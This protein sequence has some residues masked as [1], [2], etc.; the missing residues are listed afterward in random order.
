MLVVLVPAEGRSP[1]LGPEA[2]R[3]LSEVGVT[4]VSLAGD[5]E[6]VGVVLQGWAFD[7]GRSGAE[8]ADIVIE[9]RPGRVLL[10]VM[11][12]SISPSPVQR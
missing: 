5:A 2:L 10:G 8:A 3:R 9:G 7:P 11:H 12:A 1:V 4:D 6:T